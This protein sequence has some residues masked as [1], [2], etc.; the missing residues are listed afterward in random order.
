MAT[1]KSVQRFVFF[2]L[3]VCALCFDSLRLEG[4]E[5]G[6]H[7]D[8]ERFKRLVSDLESGVSGL[9]RRKGYSARVVIQ[10]RVPKEWADDL[11]AEQ[12][13]TGTEK[14]PETIQLRIRHQPFSIYL[15]WITVRPGRE[16]V[17]VDGMNDG[18][19]Y[20]SN[21]KFVRGLKMPPDSDWVKDER[22]YPVTKFGLLFL[23]KRLHEILKN[24]LDRDLGNSTCQLI[25]SNFG[26]RPTRLYTLEH[27]RQ[28]LS[29]HYRKAVVHIDK[30][31]LIPVSF[32]AYTWPSNE[33]D[34]SEVDKSTFIER[35]EYSEIDFEKV[36]VDAD[37]DVMNPQ[38]GFKVRIPN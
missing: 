9:E 3:V 15:K 12:V 19:M 18:N 6:V 7:G 34:K 5:A 4:Q 30:E 28:E 21:G 14:E 32:A 1:L 27:D 11:A 29:R 25:E 38:Y 13:R 22:R 16:I 2:A 37:F 17:F 35:Y 33:T 31:W 24:D 10:E 8:I 23:A 36:L 20:F 26:N